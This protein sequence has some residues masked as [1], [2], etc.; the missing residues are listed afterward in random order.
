MFS[1]PAFFAEYLSTDTVCCVAYETEAI[2]Y[3]SF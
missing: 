2:A 3:Y 1:F